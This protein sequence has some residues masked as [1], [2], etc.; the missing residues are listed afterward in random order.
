MLLD[1]ALSPALGFLRSGT[2]DEKTAAATLLGTIAGGRRGAATY[3][4]AE[5][6][7]PLAANLLLEG[8]GGRAGGAGG[9]GPSSV[10]C[11]LRTSFACLSR[12]TPT[13]QSKESRLSTPSPTPPTT[14]R[15]P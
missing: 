3:L 7:L 9:R 15:R 11:S 8:E 12:T 10:L 2:D 4:V 14:T 13:P 6:T 1:Q 5:G